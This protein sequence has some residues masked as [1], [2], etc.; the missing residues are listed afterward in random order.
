MWTF[1]T[2]SSSASR[3]F[4]FCPRSKGPVSVVSTL[5][6]P[7][8]R[9]SA[10]CPRVGVTQPSGV[11]PFFPSTHLFPGCPAHVGLRLP[12]RLPLGLSATTFAFVRAL[13]LRLCATGRV[14]SRHE[15]TRGSTILPS[16]GQTGH[17]RPSGYR[18]GSGGAGWGKWWW[19]EVGDKYPCTYGWRKQEKQ[20]QER[21]RM[22]VGNENEM[23]EMCPVNEG[24]SR[25]I[26][27]R[28]S[29]ILHEVRWHM[30]YIHVIR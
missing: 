10:L 30:E 20:G 22:P 13:L 7:H 26:E 25:P 19:L 27:S 28:N 29:S 4:C 1:F 24:G 6:K 11:A 14:E 17:N 3:I 2:S 15:E 8:E 12:C 9:T 16:G 21:V 5:P 23:L 18:C